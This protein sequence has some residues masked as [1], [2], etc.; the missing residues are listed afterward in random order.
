M[1]ICLHN[2]VT[3]SR[4][5]LLCLRRTCK[6]RTDSDL[7]TSTPVTP[8]SSDLSLF[9]L[10]LQTPHLFRSI[11]PSLGL[12]L[13]ALSVQTARLVRHNHSILPSLAL[14]T[15]LPDTGHQHTTLDYAL[16]SSNLPAANILSRRRTISR[17]E[18]AD[19]GPLASEHPST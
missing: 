12:L 13:F 5:P 7:Q 3:R 15:E 10:S 14:R 9:V 19:H 8:P 2:L 11:T 6:A 17:T 18:A 1:K 16:I 4:L